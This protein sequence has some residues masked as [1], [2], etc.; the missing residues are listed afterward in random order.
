MPAPARKRSSSRTKIQ[1]S[2]NR[3][4]KKIQYALC[5]NCGSPFLSHH[6]CRNC[7][8]YNGKK[9]LDIKGK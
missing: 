3:K 6:I 5:K 9:I 4:K 2:H 8:M 1:Q 7:G